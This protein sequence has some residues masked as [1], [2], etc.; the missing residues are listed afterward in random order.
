MYYLLATIYTYIY[1]QYYTL[2]CVI[3]KAVL[4]KQAPS[5]NANY[6]MQSERGKIYSRRLTG[7]PIFISTIFKIEFLKKYIVSS[8]TKCFHRSPSYKVPNLK[9]S[10]NLKLSL[11][12]YDIIQAF[13]FSIQTMVYVIVLC[14]SL[15]SFFSITLSKH[16]CK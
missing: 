8:E 9:R 14:V 11:L 16:A 1:I 10:Y 15:R 6:I 5:M 12:S 3:V 7:H 4:A 2:G 13:F